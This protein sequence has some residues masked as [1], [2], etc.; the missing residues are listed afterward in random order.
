MWDTGLVY[1]DSVNPHCTLPPWCLSL[2]WRHRLRWSRNAGAKVEGNFY[3]PKFSE[4]FFDNWGEKQE[5]MGNQAF[6]KPTYS[7]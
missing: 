1:F 2:G 7:R 5:P 4:S 6:T 3:N